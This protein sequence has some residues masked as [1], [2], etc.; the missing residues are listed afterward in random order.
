MVSVQ[1]N[2]V[3]TLVLQLQCRISVVKMQQL[4]IAGDL[5]NDRPTERDTLRIQ[6]SHDYLTLTM[7]IIWYCYYTNSYRMH[8]LSLRAM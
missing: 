1:P 3:I 4:I 2:I 8:A 5:E 7:I 6:P